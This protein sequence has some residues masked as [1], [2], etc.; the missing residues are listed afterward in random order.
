MKRSIVLSVVL[1]LLM[2]TSC[3]EAAGFGGG[4]LASETFRLW[5]RNLEAQKAELQQQYD[6]AFAELQKAPDPNSIKLANKVIEAIRDKQLVNEGTLLAVKT[7][8]QLPGKTKDEK[9]D[10][11]IA[12]AIGAAGIAYEFFTKRKL[13]MKY[14]AHKKGQAA[15]TKADPA[16]GQKLYDAIGKERSDKK[17]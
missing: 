7:A 16:A 13:G 12:A 10:V 15:F 8:L 2:T 1:L 11:F 4:A 14:T 9:T 3:D 5:E 17:L 6:L